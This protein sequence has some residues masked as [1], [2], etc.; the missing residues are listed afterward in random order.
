M[1]NKFVDLSHKLIIKEIS[2]ILNDIFYDSDEYYKSDDERDDKRDDKGDN[3]AD[4]NSKISE[5][6]VLDY[7]INN[8][9]RDDDSE[10]R[11]KWPT[12]SGSKQTGFDMPI[13][14]NKLIDISEVETFCGFNPATDAWIRVLR[15]NHYDSLQRMFVKALN[16]YTW[17]SHPVYQETSI[18]RPYGLALRPMFGIVAAG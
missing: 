8:L 16:A 2:D 1:I 18:L 11:K 10:I 12:N 3:N 7:V 17:A 9:I 14:D 15:D 6:S 4:D 13:E 5:K